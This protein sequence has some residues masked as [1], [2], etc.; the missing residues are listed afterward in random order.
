MDIKVILTGATGPVG[1]G[2]L[3]EC[4]RHPAVE[5]VLLV[6]R[7]PYEAFGAGTL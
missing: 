7:R 5:E 2:V 1:E 3:F 6:N 4:L